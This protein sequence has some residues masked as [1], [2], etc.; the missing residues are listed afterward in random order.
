MKGTFPISASFLLFSSMSHC[1]LSHNNPIKYILLE[2]F[3]IQIVY[4]KSKII[5][6]SIFHL[7]NLLDFQICKVFINDFIFMNI[8]CFTALFEAV[9]VLQANC[10]I[11]LNIGTSSETTTYLVPSPV[12]FPTAF[13]SSK[14]DP[15]LASKPDTFPF[16]WD[17]FVP[18][19]SRGNEGLVISCLC[20][21]PQCR[22][23]G[24]FPK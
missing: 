3:N 2:F 5:L 23:L 18:W 1:A 17:A 22:W 21:R 19:H 16:N 11:K 4:L 9:Q 10:A 12:F 13:S 15:R 24:V 6:T 8:L 14:G 7:I 20:S